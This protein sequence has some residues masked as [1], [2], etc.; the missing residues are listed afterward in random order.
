GTN[1]V[2]STAINQLEMWQEETFD[3]ETIDRELGWAAAIGM[4]SM[5]VFLHDLA[6]KQ[7][8][9]GFLDRVDRYL[10][11]ADKHEIRTMF[12]FFDGV[13][14]PSPQAGEQPQPRPRVHNSGWVQSPGR[15]TLDDPAKQDALKDY[16][17]AVLDRFK[18]DQRVLVWD[19][20]NEPEN[21]NAGKFGG[22]SETPDLPK[23]LKRQRA[24]ELLQKTFTWAR[25]VN[26][27]QPLTAGVWG[28]PNW[29]EDPDLIET[30]SLQHSDVITFH[31]YN[32][33]A[34]T[35][36]MIDGLKKYGRPVMCTE[37]LARGN[38]STFE[39]IL[40]IFQAHKIGA[41]NWGL[42]DGKTNTIYP[43]DSWRKK[44]DDEPDPWH[45]EVFRRDGTPYKLSEVTLIKRLTAKN[46]NKAASTDRKP[47]F[48]FILTDDQGWTG[49][50][51]PMDKSRIDSKSDFYRTP[52]IDRL[53]ASG[54]RFSRGYS[55]APNCSPS[56]YANLTGKTCA[57]LSFTDIVGRGHSTDLNGK[58]K[59]R[60]GGKATRQIREADVTI[61][62]LLKTLPDRYRTAHFGK[63]HLSGGGPGKHGFDA[64]DGSTG[65]REGSL[66]P[67]IVAD[68]KQA[69][70]LAS[71]A[72]EFIAE[73]VALDQPFY[74]QISHYAVHAKIQH[75]D[76]T[77]TRTRQWDAGSNHSDPAYA[78]MVS[79]LDQSVGMVLD[80]LERLDI[81]DNTYV[82]YQADNGSP[83]FLS[84]SPPL[85]RYKPEIW[86]GGIRVPTFISGPG[87]APNSQ[88]DQPMMGIDLLPTIW[89]LAE[90]HED[91]LPKDIDG[92]SLVSAIKAISSGAEEESFVR[93]PGELVVHSPHYVLTKDGKKNQRPS[94][95]IFDGKWKLVAWYETGEVSLF[96]LQSDI[97]ESQD[98]G[99]DYPGVK[100]DLYKRLRNYLVG[101]DAHMPTLDPK[102]SSHRDPSP[103]DADA[104]G[105]P[106][107]WEFRNLLTHRFSGDDDTD[108]DGLS[109]LTE[110]KSKTDPL[111]R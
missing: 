33:P 97:S 8:P 34:D 6:W 11:I 14:N 24:L 58:Q 104:D 18:D 69:F 96:D 1:F 82:I 55:P 100:Q 15:A 20:F 30:Y 59:L 49:L 88:C 107:E 53:A 50:S 78:A 56:R 66:G 19:L 23:G 43:W 68:P 4:N 28:G 90:G 26:P 16:V 47:N 7:D 102:H 44:Y 22:D 57:R 85:K 27:S 111:T 110:F 83:Q 87:V 46:L 37:Y 25:E 40:P 106:D 45:H 79:D 75:R 77:L 98:V 64:S 10:A 62:E 35:R 84:E 63:W 71:K 105:L 17:V 89:E 52:N 109:N 42:V 93:R 41:Y 76:Q 32:G 108:G 70:S 99:N 81:E 92:G 80:Q 72:N 103:G 95:A 73:S 60:P 12:V 74:C 29:L 101:V 36:R 61:A 48:V 54:M 94:S 31:T 2:P 21:S 38:G 65:N 67:T 3:P 91:G 5:R 86:E 39:Q 51:T 13:W 9:E